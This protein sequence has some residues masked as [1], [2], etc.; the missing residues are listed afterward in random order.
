MAKYRCK[1]DTA[2][3][4]RSCYTEH[5]VI[6]QGEIVNL[7]YMTRDHAILSYPN[8]KGYNTKTNVDV[9]DWNNF[10]PIQD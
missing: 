8:Y 7:K 9:K 4:Q 6:K 10:E 3:Y 1:E 5:I 2:A